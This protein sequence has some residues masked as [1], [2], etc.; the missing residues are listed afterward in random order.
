MSDREDYPCVQCGGNGHYGGGDCFVCNGTGDMRVWEQK[1]RKKNILD[2]LQ[3]ADLNMRGGGVITLHLQMGADW[4]MRDLA[5][6]LKSVTNEIELEADKRDNPARTGL[7]PGL[8]RR[9]LDE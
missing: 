4:T 3:D 1:M 8:I 2:K 5:E 6:L 7:E 9:H